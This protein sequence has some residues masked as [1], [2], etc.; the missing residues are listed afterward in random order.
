MG[1]QSGEGVVMSD[2]L[3]SVEWER[4]DALR[5]LHR[6]TAVL[7]YLYNDLVKSTL[8]AHCLEAARKIMDELAHP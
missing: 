8:C 1:Y 5:V 6:R 3:T 2:E 4:D 7:V